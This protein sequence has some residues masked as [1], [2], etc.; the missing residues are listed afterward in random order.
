MTILP[1]TYLGSVKYFAHLLR[2]ECVIDLGEHFI[3]RSERNRAQIMTA[4]GILALTVNVRNGNRPQTPVRD[5]RI[6]YSKRWQH[7]HRTALMSAY[8]SSP[9]FEH[10]APSLMPFYERKF[11]FLADYNLELTELLLQ[12]AHIDR[13][14]QISELYVEAADGDRDLR[15]K[16]RESRFDCPPYYQLFSERF[17]FAANLSFADL[18]LAE[19]PSAISVLRSCRL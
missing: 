10:Y 7:L 14:P 19:G 13:R 6:D 16:K 8:R 17:P 15:P 1:V 11:E 5:V 18:L 2:E 4:N 3:K 12:L 9:Y